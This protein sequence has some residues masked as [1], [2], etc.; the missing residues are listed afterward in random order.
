MVKSELLIFGDLCPDNDYRQLFDNASDGAFAP[1][2]VAQMRK[3]ALVVGNLEC[4]VTAQSKPLTKCGPNLRAKPQDIKK[5]KSCG[6]GVLSLAN[7]HILDFGTQG[8]EDTLV[9]CREANIVTVGAGKDAAEARRSVVVDVSGKRVGI[10]SFAEAEFNLAT[11]TSPGANHFD[12]YS[13][14][15]DVRA[16]SAQAD[17]VI[18]L[19]HGGIE[20]Y[21]YPSPLLQ[22]KCRKFAE[23]GADLV[24]C[25]HSHCIGTLEQFGNGTILYGQGNSL[26]GYRAG[27]A[28]WNE[29]LVAA[30]E[31]DSQKITFKLLQARENGIVFATPEEA[32]DRLERMRKD[33]EIL[34]DTALLKEKW[35]DFCQ[36][37]ASLD[38]PLL[39][40]WGHIANKLNRML[41]NC[42]FAWRYSKRKQMTTM[43]LLR[44]EAHH[45]VV[46]TILESR[47]FK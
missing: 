22:K 28:D 12:P 45:E 2:V 32:A 6:F 19:Y 38:L 17:Y 35:R 13:S 10:A 33:S 23:C 25:Q 4:P 30:V 47:V 31:L 20:H 44:C 27:N 26:F 9:S 18:V 43:N 5:L 24:R 41:G 11:E 37:Q 1:E 42:L 39:Y 36:S 7:N 16:L 15:D 21:K 8:V 34:N 46:Q 3:S 14:F 29:G 40:G